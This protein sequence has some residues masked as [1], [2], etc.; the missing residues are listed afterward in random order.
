M[1]ERFLKAGLFYNLTGVFILE[2]LLLTGKSAKMSGIISCLI[3]LAI[4]FFINKSYVFAAKKTTV[5]SIL[6]FTLHNGIIITLYAN[7]LDISEQL[8][9]NLIWIIAP[10][11]ILIIS[12]V[13]FLVFKWFVF[14]K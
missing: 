3:T 1:I 5:K 12:S 7:L 14:S 8:Y 6:V 13:N 4:S 11:I 9:P 10:I 2:I